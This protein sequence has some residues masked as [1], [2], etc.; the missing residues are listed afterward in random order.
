MSPPSNAWRE[1]YDLLI[2]PVR[3]NLPSAP[4]TLLTIVPHGPLAGLS[5]AALQDERGRYLLEKHALH[6]APAGAMLQFTAPKSHTDGRSGAV[7]VIADPVLPRPPRPQPPLPALAGARAEARAIARQIPPARITVLTGSDATKSRVMAGVERKAA[8]HFATHAIVREDAPFDSFLALAADAAAADGRLTAQE[9]Y[10]LRLDA[11]LVVLSACRSGGGRVGGDGIAS[12]ARAFIYAGTPS[13]IASVW[14]VADEATGTLIASFYRSWLA[15]TSKSRA[16]RSAQL[17]LMRD[18]RA[19]R[20]TVRTAAGP[21]V[22][23]EHPIF[24]A[25]FAL[26]GEPQ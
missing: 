14:D 11:D 5:F 12:F 13:V 8:V 24:W 15:G 22:L 19:G 18:L 21:I 26:I 2:R 6:Y 17:A 20:L 3:T 10:K 9:I 23:P 1:L 25:G 4:G 7:L 16:L